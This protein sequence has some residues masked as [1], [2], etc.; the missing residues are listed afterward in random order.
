MNRAGLEEVRFECSV[1]RFRVRYAGIF[2][3]FLNPPLDFE[4]TYQ[5]DGFCCLRK[6]L[7]M[8]AASSGSGSPSQSAGCRNRRCGKY[9]GN[10]N[11]RRVNRRFARSVLTAEFERET[12]PAVEKGNESA[13]DAREE[14]DYEGY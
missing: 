7:E 11:C 3:W 2:P 1:Q 10:V 14:C 9:C 13:P 12:N 4:I 5:I 8:T 6:C